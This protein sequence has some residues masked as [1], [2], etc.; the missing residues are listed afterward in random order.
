MNISLF[1]NE[2]ISIQFNYDSSKNGFLAIFR[3]IVYIEVPVELLIKKKIT[4][5]F[6][7]STTSNAGMAVKMWKLTS[8]FLGCC[9]WKKAII[10]SVRCSFV[11]FVQYFHRFHQFIYSFF[12]CTYCHCC[13]DIR[14]HS[15]FEYGRANEHL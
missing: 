12:L 11:C 15:A 6:V 13:S 9:C 2:F 8:F 7:D 10:S 4:N 3:K 1:V 14:I 5:W